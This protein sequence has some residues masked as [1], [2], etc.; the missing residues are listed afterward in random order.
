MATLR[1]ADKR[2]AEASHE[3]ILNRRIDLKV[4]PPLRIKEKSESE[5][6]MEPQPETEKGSKGTKMDNQPPTIKEDNRCP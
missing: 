4:T 5:P 3:K 6:L 2:I 1:F